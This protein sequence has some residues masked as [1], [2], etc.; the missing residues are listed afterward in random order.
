VA[1]DLSEVASNKI[2]SLRDRIYTTLFQI[3]KVFLKLEIEK[4]TL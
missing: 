4:E 2:Y 1:R 3:I